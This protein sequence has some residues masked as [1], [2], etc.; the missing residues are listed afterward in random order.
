MSQIYTLCGWF[1]R[2]STKN[3]V[4][5]VVWLIVILNYC[6]LSACEFYKCCNTCKIHCPSSAVISLEMLVSEIH[7]KYEL[8][9]RSHTIKHK[10]MAARVVEELIASGNNILAACKCANVDQWFFTNQRSFWKHTDKQPLI[11]SYLD[12]SALYTEAGQA[13]L[14]QIEKNSRG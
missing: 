1:Q 7:K 13:S 5:V 11:N 8:Q 14:P 2:R 10:H 12:I 9:Q 4:A 3:L 6:N